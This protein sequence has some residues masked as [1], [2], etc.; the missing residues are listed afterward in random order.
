M[1]SIYNKS[2]AKELTICFSMWNI[3]EVIGAIDRYQRRGWITENQSSIALSNLAGETLRLTQIEALEL[4]PLNSFALSETWDLIRKHHIYQAD[5]VQILE[6]KRSRA[7]ALLSADKPLL[8]VGENEGLAT[9]DI[10]DAGQVERQ[11]S[12]K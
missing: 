11:I 10:E 2:D 12:G 7:D 6:C 8:E 1:A 4:L 9:V 3:G 5:A